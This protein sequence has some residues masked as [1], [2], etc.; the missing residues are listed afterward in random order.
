MIPTEILILD[1]EATELN[2]VSFPRLFEST[3]VI[4]LSQELIL[5]ECLTKEKAISPDLISRSQSCIES[6]L[7]CS[8]EFVG[9]TYSRPLYSLSNTL[10]PRASQVVRKF[11]QDTGLLI[12]RIYFGPI[13]MAKCGI[14]SEQINS[15][16]LK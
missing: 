1:Q 4:E 14:I 6:L 13:N 7:G 15:E 5:A 3:K 11:S 9:E 2:R 8:T 10:L 16:L 12:P